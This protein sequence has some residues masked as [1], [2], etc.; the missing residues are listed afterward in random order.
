MKGLL[1]L[2]VW[3]L[4]AAMLTSC[5]TAYQKRG[6]TGGY[7]ENKIDDSHYVVYF[8]GNGYA[9]KDRV[10]YFWIYR[11]AQLTREKGFSYFSIE[12][13]Q[14]NLNKSAFI[15]EQGRHLYTAVLDG[16]AD[17]HVIN[18]HAGGGGVAFI[19]VPG[20]TIVTWH[21]RAIVAMYGD[22]LP[23]RKVALRAQTVLDML[24][25]YIRTNGS[26]MP[27]LRDD[28]FAQ[29]SYAVAPDNQ[30]VNVHD[31][32]LTHFYRPA[33]TVSPSAA[34]ERRMAMPP[35]PPPP[36]IPVA[37][38]PIATPIAPAAV[39]P[40][41]A[42]PSQAAPVSTPIASAAQTVANQ[43][44]CGAVQPNGASTFTAAC[45]SYSVLIGCDGDQC[46]PMHT[47]KAKGGE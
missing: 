47:I 39:A 12:P 31:Y 44:G 35:S 9:S 45:G 16:D 6:L 18:V 29:A 20:G 36:P 43:L 38:P 8:N 15:P 5:A 30:L 32:L 41:A 34:M 28:L 13:I 22:T 26:S 46:R 3:M 1:K 17:G 40:V 42:I 10:W 33:I 14:S 24:A 19:Y 2:V 25:E 21:S 4:M 23:Q 7:G 11:C 27:P 37:T